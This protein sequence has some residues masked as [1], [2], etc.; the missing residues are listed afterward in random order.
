MKQQNGAVAPTGSACP[1]KAIQGQDTH[2]HASDSRTFDHLPD[3]SPRPV[4]AVDHTGKRRGKMTAIAW[5]RASRS[6]KG[7]V[8]LCRCECGRYEY[9]RPGTWV[10]KPLPDDR[11]KICLQARGPNAR[12]TAPRRLQQWQQD[13][14]DLGLTDEEIGLLQAPGMNVDTRGRTVAQIREQLAKGPT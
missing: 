3:L 9:R 2:R 7:T 13:M 11:C 6:G 8:W 1:K 4:Q 12:Q 10:S 14:R 5:V